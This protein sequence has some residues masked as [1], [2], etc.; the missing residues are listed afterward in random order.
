MSNENNVRIKE[1]GARITLF[2]E[3]AIGNW[4]RLENQTIVQKILSAAPD[5]ANAIVQVGYEANLDRGEVI[6]VSP[7]AHVAS[8]GIDATWWVE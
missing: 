1:R 4:C 6:S 3:I 7:G 8:L 5:G 2:N